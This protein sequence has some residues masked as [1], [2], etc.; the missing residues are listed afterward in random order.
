M[1]DKYHNLTFL[2]FIN[3][4][5][6]SF[7]R[8]TKESLLLLLLKFVG[9]SMCVAECEY[10]FAKEFNFTLLDNTIPCS[11]ISLVWST[12]KD[13]FLYLHDLRTE[14]NAWLLYPS[15]HIYEFHNEVVFNWP[16]YCRCPVA[17]RRPTH[18]GLK[19]FIP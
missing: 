3:K 13:I 9:L 18:M 15:L 5:E 12:I 6:S 10:L 2:R 16:I 7:T 19:N 17:L 4:M 1:L 14:C 11:W 8:P